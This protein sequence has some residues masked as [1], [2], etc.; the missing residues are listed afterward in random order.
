MISRLLFLSQ[1]S[2]S[3]ILIYTRYSKILETMTIAK[4]ILVI[5]TTFGQTGPKF[6]ELR[7]IRDCII[8]KIGYYKLYTM[9]I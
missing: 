9:I 4:N 8:M 3:L 5:T 2:P 1:S 7:V 6:T